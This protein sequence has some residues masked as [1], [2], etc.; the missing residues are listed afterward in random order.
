MASPLTMYVQIKQDAVSQELAEKAVAN[1][2]QGVQAGLDAAEIVHYATLALVPNPATTPGTPASGYMGLLLMTDFDLAMNPYLETF[3]N[4]GGGIKTAI[5]GI[6]LIAYNPVPPINTLTD[7]QNFIN[8]VNL[9]PAPT[10]GNWTNFY[11]AYN[12]TVKQINA[13]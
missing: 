3:W 1:F 12:L 5:Q 10:S 8:S 9:T 11:Q 13:D 4:A 2:T 6:A 7:F